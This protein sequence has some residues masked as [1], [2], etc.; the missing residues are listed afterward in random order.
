MGQLEADLDSLEAEFLDEL[1]HAFEMR[2]L[3]FYVALVSCRV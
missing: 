1:Q 3:G 2:L